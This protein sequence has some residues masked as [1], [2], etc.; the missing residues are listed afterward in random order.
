MTG[1]AALFLMAA[2]SGDQDETKTSM[3]TPR[4]STGTIFKMC[5]GDCMEQTPHELKA[6]YSQCV[7]CGNKIYAKP[8]ETKGQNS[9][10][11]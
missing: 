4:T 10:T 8:A 7:I 9:H 1:L 11:G 6:G 5:Q 2:A 3:P